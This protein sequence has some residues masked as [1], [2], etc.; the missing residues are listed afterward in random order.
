[1]K[2]RNTVHAKVSINI[3]TSRELSQEELDEYLDNMNYEFD[4]H[5]DN[6]FDIYTDW[7]D[8]EIVNTNV[9]Y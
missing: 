2:Y 8:T 7:F 3:F 4:S 1:M 9:K 6:G 5:V